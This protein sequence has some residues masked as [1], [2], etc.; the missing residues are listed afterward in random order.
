MFSPSSAKRRASDKD[1]PV[2][3]LIIAFLKWKNRI[4]LQAFLYEGFEGPKILAIIVKEI[5]MN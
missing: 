3:G 2:R 5:E 1:L 4:G